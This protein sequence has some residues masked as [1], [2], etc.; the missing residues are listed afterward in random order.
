[1]HGLAHCRS[2]DAV[3]ILS[4]VNRD[5]QDRKSLMLNAINDSI[6]TCAVLAVAFP[7]SLQEFAKVRV[8]GE[9]INGFGD[10]LT[11]LAVGAD[12]AVKLFLSE[13]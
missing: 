5:D 6:A 4:V 12:E 1:M 9:A 11:T 8:D 2:T 13:F 10:L 7:L 3:H